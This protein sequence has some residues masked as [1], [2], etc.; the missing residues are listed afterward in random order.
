M[1]VVALITANGLGMVS[2]GMNNKT[3]LKKWILKN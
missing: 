3:K 1:Q 2:A